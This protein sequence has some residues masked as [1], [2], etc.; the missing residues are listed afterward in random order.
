MRIDSEIT[1]MVE[2]LRLI[3]HKTT[4]SNHLL[5]NTLLPLS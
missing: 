5:D 3:E 2:D 1:F 4:E